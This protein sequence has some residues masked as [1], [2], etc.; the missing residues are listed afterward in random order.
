MASH[1]FSLGAR[2]E[3][4]PLTLVRMVGKHKLGVVFITLVLCAI[5]VVIVMMLPAVYRAEA[6]ILV[7]SQKIPERDSSFLP[8][9][10][11][12]PQSVGS[13]FHCSGCID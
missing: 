4:A 7:D 3:F 5:S 9:T 12:N 10:A 8:C 13:G 11:H 2:A 6:L 1:K